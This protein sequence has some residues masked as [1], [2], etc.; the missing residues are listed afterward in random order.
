M[1]KTAVFF[2]AYLV[3]HAAFSQKEL[4]PT[5]SFTISGEVKNPVVIQASDLKKWSIHPIGDVIITN[6]LGERKS[7]AKALKGVLL[8]DVLQSIE[9]N[10]ENP[11]VLSEYYF[12]CKSTDGYTAVYSWNE[13]FNTPTGNTAYLVTEREGKP[14]TEMNDAVLMISSGD[15]KTG[16]RHLKALTTIEIKRAK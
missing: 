8:K 11:R 2:F 5:D 10:A 6:H 13:L 16:R 15:F 12:V 3:V 1:R 9:I 14:L 4:K 7:E